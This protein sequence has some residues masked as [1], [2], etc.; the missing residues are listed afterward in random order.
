VHFTGAVYG[1]ELAS[2][3]QHATLVVSPSALEGLSIALLEAMSF[4]RPVLVSDIPENLEVVEGV[5]ETFRAGDPSDLGA[6]LQ[7]LLAAPDHLA[8]LGRRGRE[9]IEKDYSW[10]EVVRQTARVYEDLGPGKRG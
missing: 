2:L 4:G 7:Q 8:E 10:E 6:R 9:R 3:W 1:A 5:G